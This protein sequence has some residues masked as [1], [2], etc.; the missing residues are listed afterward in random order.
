MSDRLTKILYGVRCRALKGISN[1]IGILDDCITEEMHSEFH[2]LSI[3]QVNT[4]QA[5]TS[6]IETF[7]A[8]NKRKGSK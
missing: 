8:Q 1:R 6:D 5:I 3:T 7:L 4:W 2:H